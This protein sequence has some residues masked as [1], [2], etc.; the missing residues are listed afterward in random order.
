MMPDEQSRCCTTTVFSMSLLSR[1][2]LQRRDASPLISASD[3]RPSVVSSA[4]DLEPKPT[5]KLLRLALESASRAVDID[6]EPVARRCSPANAEWVRVW[7]G[8]HY[9]LLAGIVDVLQPSLV[10]EI[11]TFQ[12]SGSLAML[13]R[14]PADSRL[15]TFDIVPWSETVECALQESD[16]ADGRL[17]QEIGDLSDPA[18]FENQ[19]ELLLQADLVFMDAPKDGV[20]EPAFLR[21]AAP[22]WKGSERLLIFDDIRLMP[23]VQLWRDLPF[24]KLDLTSFGHWSGTGFALTH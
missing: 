23:M 24:P 5:P 16:F 20:F 12:G 15:V 13:E 14:L 7:P 19:R 17:V 4:I 2:G 21:L 6:L 8:E 18:V 22:L 1:V 11:G 9:R 3:A 10:V